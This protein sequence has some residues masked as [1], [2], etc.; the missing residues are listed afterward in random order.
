MAD[1]LHI[2]TPVVHTLQVTV[3]ALRIGTKQVTQSVFRQ[4]PQRPIWDQETGQILGRP[5]GFVNYFWGDCAPDHQHIVWQDGE[6]LYRDCVYH[7][8]RRPPP[9]LASAEQSR[10][11]TAA[12]LDDA[13]SYVCA[14]AVWEHGWDFTPRVW[15]STM[16]V[17]W[18]ATLTQAFEWARLGR[19]RRNAR[20]ELREAGAGYYAWQAL[21]AQTPEMTKRG[22]QT[23]YHEPCPRDALPAPQNAWSRVGWG[24][25][26]EHWTRQVEESEE[27]WRTRHG[28]GMV[29]IFQQLRAALDEESRED[30]GLE[31]LPPT[32]AAAKQALAE[33]AQ[34][35]TAAACRCATL[36]AAFLRSYTQLLTL[37][38]LFIA[39]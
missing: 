4:L 15:P 3:Q 30:W 8:Q 5:W 9:G 21:R 12:T 1:V 2:A 32:A 37:E 23:E 7:P 19:T 33:V 28:A 26:K 34:S 38:Q 39:V 31:E 36:E 20:G 16:R 17:V 24:W 14:V 25:R 18:S 29:T 22:T 6:T 10:R 27:A 13:T 35:Y 11:A